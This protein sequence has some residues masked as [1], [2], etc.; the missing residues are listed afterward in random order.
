MNTAILEKELFAQKYNPAEILRKLV[1]DDINLF[2]LIK[3]NVKNITKEQDRTLNSDETIKRIISIRK[4]KNWNPLIK[5]SIF[6]WELS[7]DAKLRRVNS[8]LPTTIKAQKEWFKRIFL[9]KEN[10]LEAIERLI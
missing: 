10:G 1:E 2:G 3:D 5:D 4:D 7:L 6:I 9:P 8:I